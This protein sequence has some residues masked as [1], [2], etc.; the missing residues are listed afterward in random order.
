ML[1]AKLSKIGL[2]VCLFQRINVTNGDKVSRE[3]IDF[4]LTD[5]ITMFLL[6]NKTR[7]LSG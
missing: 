3:P 6:E 2:F 5:I 4:Y 7:I 1:F